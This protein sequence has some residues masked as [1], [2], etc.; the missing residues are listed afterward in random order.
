MLSYTIIYTVEKRRIY[1]NT[2]ENIKNRFNKIKEL[3]MNWTVYM[4]REAEEESRRD[5]LREM[6]NDMLYGTR[7]NEWGGF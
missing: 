7:K 6:L 3:I 2:N 4:V 5:E 1:M